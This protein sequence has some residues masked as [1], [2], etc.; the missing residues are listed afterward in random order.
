M[1]NPLFM[2]YSK[3]AVIV[4]S[5]LHVWKRWTKHQPIKGE[6]E[7]SMLLWLYIVLHLFCFFLL[8]FHLSPCKTSQRRNVFFLSFNFW[9]VHCQS[10]DRQHGH[11]WLM[12][13]IL[14]NTRPLMNVRQKIK[15]RWKGT[16]QMKETDNAKS[17]GCIKQKNEMLRDSVAPYS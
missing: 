8:R 4:S 9:G 2:T 11:E 14:H 5:S 13:W 7:D 17:E 6:F 3:H 12:K 15:L 10:R 1:F 16:S